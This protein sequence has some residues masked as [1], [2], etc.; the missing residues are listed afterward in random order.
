MNITYYILNPLKSKSI[1]KKIILFLCFLP[2]ILQAQNSNTERLISNTRPTITKEQ[3]DS[4][5][6]HSDFIFEGKK[7]LIYNTLGPGAL[8]ATAKDGFSGIS[9][10]FR[11]SRVL[12][13]PNEYI[14]KIVEVHTPYINIRSEIVT[15]GDNRIIGACNMS[16]TQPSFYNMEDTKDFYQKHG[17]TYSINNRS[18]FEIIGSIKEY[19]RGRGTGALGLGY[20]INNYEV[21]FDSLLK[22]YPELE[23]LPKTKEAI[24][25]EKAKRESWRKKNKGNSRKI[26]IS[27]SLRLEK[28]KKKN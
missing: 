4:I 24:E 18:S 3:R 13:G 8:L 6:K 19:D 16:S 14:D 7:L 5:F 27:D 22:E 28:A 10:L 9:A 2:F 21:A 11:V 12:K 20:S 1:M 17:T 23:I 25:K 15:L 26:F